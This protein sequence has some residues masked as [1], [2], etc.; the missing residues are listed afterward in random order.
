MFSAVDYAKAR[1]V[2]IKFTTPRSWKDVFTLCVPCVLDRDLELR[3]KYGPLQERSWAIVRAIRQGQNPDM[4]IP[5]LPGQGHRSSSVPSQGHSWRE[6]KVEDT[7]RYADVEKTSTDYPPSRTVYDCRPAGDPALLRQDRRQQGP[8]WR[9]E[10]IPLKGQY[11][12]NILW[13]FFVACCTRD[14]KNDKL[15]WNHTSL[16]QNYYQSVAVTTYH[17][18]GWVITSHRGLWNIVF[19]HVLILNKL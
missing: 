15:L 14:L 6:P 9:E 1:L 12:Q 16:C 11:L 4:V 17:V 2:P 19:P 8:G 18:Y 13:R 3:P 10:K 7:R 5:P